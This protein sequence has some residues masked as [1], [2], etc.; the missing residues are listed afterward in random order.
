MET[1]DFS[2]LYTALPHDEI[3][4]KFSKIFKKVFEREAKLF[5]NVTYN[6]NYFSNSEIQNGCSFRLSDMNEILDFILDNI[7]VKYGK[8]IYKQVIGIPIGLDSGQDI[9]N[10]LL[11]CYESDYV[12]K[13]S[14]ENIP[15]A[16]KFNFNRRYID[17]LFVANFPEF[18]DHIYKIY[19]RELEIKLESDNP[20]QLSYL[21]LQIV[22]QNGNLI[23]TVYDKRDDFN[24]S[25]V[26]YPFIDSCIPKKSALGVYTSQLIRYARICSHFDDFKSKS[27]ILVSKL[28]N[29]G[30]TDNDLK[31]LTLR[32][33]KDRQA[34]LNKYNINDANIFLRS[35]V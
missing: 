18:K 34:L 22:S 23:F 14:K 29:Q 3:K 10:L 20:K 26:N 1:Y 24:F 11:F 35:I 28:K 21:D 15:L 17:D 33:F 6:R 16:R 4:K 9:A 19:P 8:D 32:F 31:R 25:I 5:L 30:Y 27:K 7:F 13:L 2:T 12:E